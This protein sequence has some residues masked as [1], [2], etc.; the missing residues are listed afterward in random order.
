MSKKILL[1]GMLDSI[2]FGRWLE[3]FKDQD[4]QIVIFP[5]KIFR[6]THS[7]IINLV[8]NDNFIF[9]N[10]FYKFKL[11]GYIDFI[12]SKCFTHLFRLDYRIW[13]FNIAM[14]KH[15]YYRV[16]ALEMQGAGY[17]CLDWTLEYKVD[18]SN[19][20]IVTN[21]GSDIYFFMQD[22]KH[23]NKIKKVLSIASFYSAEC[24][25]DYD[26]AVQLGFTGKFLPC[27]PNSGG[28]IF[29]QTKQMLPASKRDLLLVKGYGGSF[30]QANLAISAINCVLNDFPQ[31]KIFYYS[32][33][34]DVE[35]L[36]IAQ[37]KI[38]MNDIN[39]SLVDSP[40]PYEKILSFFQN[41]K[42]YLGISRSDGISTSFLEALSYGA[43]PI[44]SNTSCANEWV[45]KGIQCTLVDL[46]IDQ[47]EN[48]LRFILKN[49]DLLDSIVSK[50]LQI[51]TH[52]LNYD[53]I[54]S[55]SLKFYE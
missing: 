36:I 23:L 25:R 49:P 11:S 2:H 50:N 28:V 24:I 18:F 45:D 47:I 9:V 48:A 43:Y 4:V 39:Y 10:K 32:V 19:N 8:N 54:A 31:L 38:L 51:A 30:G 53:R 21:W 35:P 12:L 42:I 15:E 7:N 27:N 14:K 55:D 34:K 40:L 20:L 5:S 44:Q 3:Q 37:K 16:H 22:A 13:L 52:L 41:A 6:Y 33:T 46:N 29:N 26:L 1:I 17:L